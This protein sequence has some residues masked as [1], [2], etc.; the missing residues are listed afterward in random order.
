MTPPAPPAAAPTPA[1]AAP[2][3]AAPPAAEEEEDD[4]S[5]NPL[6]AAIK[7]AGINKLRKAAES[8][9]ATSKAEKKEEAK[10]PMSVGEELR[11]KLL[12]RNA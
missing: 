12:K 11:M 7:S 8:V 1:A 2:A 5:G 10:K 9:I 3:A 4:S 6:L